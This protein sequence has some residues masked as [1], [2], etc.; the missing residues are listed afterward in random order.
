MHS[1]YQMQKKKK[2]LKQAL[3]RTY[4]LGKKFF[5]GATFEDL[6]AVSFLTDYKKLV[7]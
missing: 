3:P 6:L 7:I 1:Y 2:T 5:A 4:T